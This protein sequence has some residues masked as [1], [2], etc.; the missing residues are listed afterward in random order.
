MKAKQKHTVFNTYLFFPIAMFLLFTSITIA[1]ACF[2]EIG[3]AIGFGIFIPLPIA[4]F[5]LV[6][7]YFVFDEKELKIVYNFG[8]SLNIEWKSVRKIYIS[9]YWFPSSGRPPHY[10]FVVPQTKEKPFFV[11][12]E[13]PKT[14]KNKKL[15]MLYYGGDIE[16]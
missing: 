12:P 4:V 16:R 11:V 13:I 14:R 9:G 1:A 5:L 10:V 8:Q 2:G 3:L 7:L 15:I 6:P